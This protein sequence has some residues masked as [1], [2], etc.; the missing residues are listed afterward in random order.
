PDAVPDDPDMPTFRE[1][2]DALARKVWEAA[3]SPPELDEKLSA[4][5]LRR[6]ASCGF[7][8]ADSFAALAD[9]RGHLRTER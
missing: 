3:G 1:T 7:T 8:A 5:I 4:K 9:L 2:A 6:L